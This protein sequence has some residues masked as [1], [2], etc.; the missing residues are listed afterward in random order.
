MHQKHHM[1]KHKIHIFS[2]S[3]LIRLKKCIFEIV[4]KFCSETRRI[5]KN[6]CFPVKWKREHT[7]P[8]SFCWMSVCVCRSFVNCWSTCATRRCT[9]SW[10][11][12][13]HGA[14]SSTDP[15]AVERPF[16]PRRWRGWVLGPRGPGPPLILLYHVFWSFLL[17]FLPIFHP[18]LFIYLEHAQKEKK[19]KQNKWK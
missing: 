8:P 12:F 13:L 7:K 11:W 18:I 16:W 1:H 19:I 14:S 17:F 5:C 10:A 15:P 4:I 2:K 3:V 9:G 6:I